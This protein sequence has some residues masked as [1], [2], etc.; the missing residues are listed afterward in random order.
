MTGGLILRRRL[1]IV[2]TY[3]PTPYPNE[4][5]YSVLCR[6]HV[7]SGYSKHATTSRELYGDKS[8]THGRL[9]PGTSIHTIAPRHP[10]GIDEKRLLME[11]T[12]AP[13]YM[14][15]FAP[16][17]KDVILDR[18]LHGKAAGITSIDLYGLDGKQGLRY[19]PRCYDQDIGRYGEPY[20]HREH[21]IPLMPLCPEHSVPLVRY[22]VLFSRLSEQYIP[23]SSIHP[24]DTVGNPAADWEIALTPTLMQFLTMPF[25]AGPAEGYSNLFIRLLEKGF[26]SNKM[27]EKPSLDKDKV[28]QALQDRYGQE[29]TQ[30]YFP[31]LSN[32]ILS[33]ICNWTMSAPER[34]ALLAVLAD[35]PAQE[36]FGPPISYQDPL[37]AQLL[38]YR[39]KGTVYRK[40]ELAQRI[41]VSPSQLD[42]LA[43][44][45]AIS[46]FWKQCN[47]ETK[48]QDC[49]RIMLTP[50]EK[51][52]VC[53]AAAISGNGQIAVFARAIL[54][55]QAKALLDNREGDMSDG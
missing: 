2:L 25:E 36:L 45:C 35:I 50:A 8:V 32:A 4:W 24:K 34:Y 26:G 41:G 48:R 18:L 21:Q 30:R 28:T 43:R 12:L 51:E 54:L 9:F 11:N 7:R 27:H 40:E 55:K 1:S 3:F 37:L 33:R 39:E 23:L 14:R 5:W 10:A 20:W 16:K 53:K 29:I 15:F 42:S 52:L 47:R 46:P 22:E 13:Y 19:C 44:K 6:Y 31:K 17:K 38:R 49:V